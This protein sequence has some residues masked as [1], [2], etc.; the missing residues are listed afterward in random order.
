MSLFGAYRAVFGVHPRA[1]TML[2]RSISEADVEHFVATRFENGLAPAMEAELVDGIRPLVSHHNFNPHSLF[3]NH[4]PTTISNRALSLLFAHDGLVLSDPMVEILSLTR[5]GEKTQALSRF[6]EITQGL[7]E[8]EPLIDAGLL[9]FTPYRPTTRENRRSRVLSHFGIDPDLTVF[10]N[11][12]EAARAA[13]HLEKGGGRSYIDQVHDLYVLFGLEPPPQAGVSHAWKAARDL[14]QTLLHL[15]WT[16]SVCSADPSADLT[17]HNPMEEA[18]FAHLVADDIE[19]VLPVIAGHTNTRHFERLATGLL[20]NIQTINLTVPDTVALRKDD[21]FAQFRDGLKV[22]LSAYD[23]TL[24]S[25]IRLQEER[26]RSNFQSQMRLL[27]AQLQ[28][29]AKKGQ[30]T[31]LLRDGSIATGI[32]AL[33]IAL[34]PVASIPLAGASSLSAWLLGR[35]TFNGRKIAVRYAAILGTEALRPKGSR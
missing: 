32:S 27:S 10:T 26:S 3:S 19:L 11:F 1:L 24:D 31:D 6:I 22:A 12:E 25:P 8:L 28:N 2:S 33:T 9:E 29:Q 34:P 30:F 18:L 13:W 35:R 5:G 21:A 4:E 23:A 20:P 7:A 14:A 15:S 16:V 17:L